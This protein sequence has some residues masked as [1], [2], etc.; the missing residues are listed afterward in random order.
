MSLKFIILIIFVAAIL[1][2][3]IFLGLGFL[4]RGKN[5]KA[6]KIDYKKK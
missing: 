1:I 3:T 5:I 2:Y 4:L 6:Q